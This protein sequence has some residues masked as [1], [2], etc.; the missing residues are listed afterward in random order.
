MQDLLNIMRTLRGPDGCP[1][2]Q[3]QTHE[4]LRPYMLE[5]AAEAVDAI[6]DPQELTGELGDVL[7]QVAFHSVIAE[8]EGTFTYQDVE[9]SIVDKLIRRHP[10]VFSD[11]KAE[12][13]EEVFANWNEIKAAERQG[14]PRSAA[15]QI[16]SAL[17]A[18][19]RETKAQKLTGQPKG[20]LAEAQA[21]IASASN[22][23]NGVTQALCAVV[24]WARSLGVDPEIVLRAHT[25]QTLKSLPETQESI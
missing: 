16:P 19:T 9:Q 15:E 17:S 1:W 24:A 5:E 3:E 13:S 10:H 25:Q 8:Q 23:E 20:N 21:A 14:K 12:T 22:D 11:V 18:L 7:L 2:D 4:S 6:G